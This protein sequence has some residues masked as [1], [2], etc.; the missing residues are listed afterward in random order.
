MSNYLQQ[1]IL[2][3]RHHRSNVIDRSEFN[4]VI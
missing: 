4:E 2:I 3:I 1:I